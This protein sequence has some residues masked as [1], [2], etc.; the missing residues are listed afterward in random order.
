ML[1]P[2]LFKIM[3]ED[4]KKEKGIALSL[5]A[6]LLL[7]QAG[8]VLKEDGKYY[9]GK[10]KMLL[11]NLLQD[12]SGIF[13]NIKNLRRLILSKET[14]QKVEKQLNQE[15]E[16]EVME[17]ELDTSKRIFVNLA[18]LYIMGG[19]DKMYDLE[20]ITSNLLENKRV[21]TQDEVVDFLKKYNKQINPVLK[22]EDEYL[23]NNF[24]K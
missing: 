18:S 24:V 9:K 17:E 7:E 21:F 12:S 22:L 11:N 4:T 1:A 3:T 6:Y 5:I 23:I 8:S 13:L 16:Q 14:I 19:A 10:T 15:I 20:R 2:F